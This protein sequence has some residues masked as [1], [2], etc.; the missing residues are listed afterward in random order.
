MPSFKD[1]LGQSHVTAP[2]TRRALH[3]AMI[4]GGKRRPDDESIRIVP[5]RAR[6]RLERSTQLQ[7]ES[8]ETLGPPLPAE[9][10]LG[11]HEVRTDKGTHK[12]WLIVSPEECSP[13]PE[14]QSWGWALQLYALRSKASWGIGD[15]SDLREFSRWS[16]TRTGTAF[17]LLNPLGA[18]L[19][20]SPQEDSPYFPS[21]RLFLNPLYLRI[22]EVPGAR[23]ADIAAQQRRGRTLGQEPLIDRDEVYR[24]KMHALRSLWNRYSG[25]ARF[26]SFRTEQGAILRKFAVFMVL[27][28]RYGR[29]WSRWPVR[30]R[31]PDGPAI[32]S[33]AAANERD[34]L[35]HEWTQWLLDAQLARAAR[36]LPL[37]LDLPIGVNPEG[38]DAWLWQDQ[39]AQGIAVGAPPD[40]YNTRGQDWGLPPFIPHRLRATGYEPWRLTLRAMLRHARGLRID[41][42]MGLFRL[43]WIPRGSPPAQGAF[44]RYAAD[45][46]L[47][48]LAIESQRAGAVVVGEDLGTVEP[49]TR[50]RLRRRR[51]LSY[52]L[53]WF[54]RTAP[55]RYPEEA[56]AAVT[57]HDLFTIAGLWT[58]SDLKEQQR[59]NLRPNIEGTHAIRRRV[60]KLADLGEDD[61]LPTVIPRVHQILCRTP[62]KLL[63][64]TLDDA[65]GA[66]KRPNMPATT[67]QWPNWRL[68][69]PLSLEQIRKAPLVRKVVTA[70]NQ[71]D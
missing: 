60:A 11:V 47:A 28:E 2:A 66:E 14:N 23:A 65:V 24:L 22:E 15:F 9:L 42:V 8:G 58:G 19:P 18:A 5:L 40:E 69:L 30:F 51:I 26:E 54:E 10:P 16:R 20:G 36:E 62:C 50:A 45:E 6:L 32:Q 35:F 64:A 31:R 4:T 34:V 38:F 39:I 48:I 43:Y 70:M 3:A 53:L 57:T 12:G 68:A 1:A 7:L 44:V 37:M 46:L 27:N 63:T 21:S 13:A 61:P 33:F 17:C 25:E 29:G 52:R 56:L 41:H 67:T 49:G 71:T 55:E 59:L